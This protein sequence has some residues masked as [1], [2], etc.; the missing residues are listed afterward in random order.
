M[1]NETKD[2]DGDTN[3]DADFELGD[4]VTHEQYGVGE[5]KPNPGERDGTYVY[6][7]ELKITTSVKVRPWNL[8]KINKSGK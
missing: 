3:T 8:S 5:V 6:F 2:V 4:A 1:H 7:E